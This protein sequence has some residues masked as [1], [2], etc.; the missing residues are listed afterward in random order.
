[1]RVLSVLRRSKKSFKK[2]SSV[3]LLSFS[4]SFRVASCNLVNGYVNRLCE[5]IHAWFHCGQVKA[6]LGFR[7]VFLIHDSAV[8]SSGLS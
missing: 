5:G 6:D 4:T 3:E 2:C 8:S 7:S 1:M